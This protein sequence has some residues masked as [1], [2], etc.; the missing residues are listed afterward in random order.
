MKNVVIEIDGVRHKL[1][2]A[3]DNSRC[4]TCSLQELC[5]E[6]WEQSMDCN[7]CGSLR[8][9]SGYHFELGKKEK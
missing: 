1:V 4:D 5:N 3:K 9:N 2:E 6:A 8:I 7:I